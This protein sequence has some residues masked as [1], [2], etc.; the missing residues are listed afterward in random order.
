MKAM[1]R[2]YWRAIRSGAKAFVNSNR[3]TLFP[4][5]HSLK[6]YTAAFAR[7]DGAAGINVALLAFPQGMAYATI[8]GLP[9]EYGIY[10]SAVAAIIGPI[11][12]GSRFIVLGP[13][14]A[15][16]VLLFTSFLAI[17]VSGP[18]KL[19]MLPFLTMLVGIFLI[20]G[21]VL[22][23][24]S[25][26]QY[27]SRTVVTGYITAAA[28]YII[29]NQVRKVLGFEF[30]IPEGTTFFGIVSLTVTNLPSAH[31]PSLALSLIT[32]AT[33]LILSRRFKTLPNVALALFIASLVAFGLNTTLGPENGSITTLG[34]PLA[35][36]KGVDASAWAPALP[37][38]QSGWMSKLAG[39]ALILAF[40]SILEGSSIGKSLAARSGERLDTNQEMFGMG[41]ANVACSVYGGMPASGSLSRSNLN[42]V[43]G[44]A[45]PMASI[46]SG[47]LCA[48]IA[49]LLG[50]FIAY[51][52]QAALGTVVIFI[53]ATLISRYHIRVVTKTTRSDAIVFAVTFLAGLLIKLEF[54]II[55][56][57][58]TSIILFL[59]KAAVPELIEYTA[60]DSGQLTPLE[61][62]KARPN[63]EIS[64][65]HVEGEL[66]FGAAE[67][68][69]NQMRR[70]VEDPN[71][72][73][74]VL[75]MR[76]SRHLDATSVLSLIELI[77][78]MREQDRYLLV[79][80]ARKEVIRVFKN[81]GLIEVIGRENI[82]ADAADNPTLST[83]KALRRAQEIIG[84]R[85]ADVSIYVN[86]K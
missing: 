38:I 37:P 32:A 16:S 61:P 59:K 24:A 85:K 58:V 6:G 65:V 11:F 13:T 9:I 1:G 3:L 72:K 86:R 2:Y 52:P 84:D 74:V 77:E 23:V 45:T 43:S 78:Y 71:L 76:N 22:R 14:N 82:F 48:G 28:L 56:G 36:L 40:L 8:A 51:I 46:M 30:E 25:L 66:F 54:G 10:G 33:F 50:A 4:A 55:L 47:L 63:P 83:A 35:M 12:S 49:V 60:N 75:K 81:S 68:F 19:M 34:G 67:L 64:I 73:V 20:T 42:F 57:A 53:G 44:A 80:E 29:I 70:V 21:A 18:E 15:T 39:T 62:S 41:L 26:I 79:S 7:R 69:R 5:R 31:L 27:V 17:H